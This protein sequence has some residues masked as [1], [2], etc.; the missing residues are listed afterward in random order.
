MRRELP[1][2]QTVARSRRCESL[3]RADEVQ[4]EQRQRS[5]NAKYRVDKGTPFYEAKPKIAY[6]DMLPYV[7]TIPNCVHK[8]EV[9]EHNYRRA[10]KIHYDVGVERKNL[11]CPTTNNLPCPICAYAANLKWE[12][13]REQIMSLRARDRDLFNII[14]L[15]NQESGVQLWDV[16]YHAFGKLLDQEKKMNPDYSFMAQLEQGYTLRVRFEEDT[17]G[18]F[19]YIKAARIDFE[20]RDDYQPDIL[21]EVYDL[22]AIL[23]ILPYDELEAEFL[24]VDYVP[25]ETTTSMRKESQPSTQQS[26]YSRSVPTTVESPH[27]PTNTS[28]LNDVPFDTIDCP[29]GHAFGIDTDKTDDCAECDVWKEC[30]QSMDRLAEIAAQTKKPPRRKR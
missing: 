26:R 30:R 1:Q 16:S 6:I 22:D 8:L 13:D 23:D 27:A 11:V 12:T 3:Q 24:G 9:G 5:R 19:K 29:Y 18:S 28:P 25:D 15:E 20:P 4:R 10:V 17:T 14:D 7:V 2:Q 21:K